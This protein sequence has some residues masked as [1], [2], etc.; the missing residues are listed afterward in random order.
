MAGTT[1]LNLSGSYTNGSISISIP[2]PAAS[3]TVA[4]A[5]ADFIAETIDVATGTANA[6]LPLPVNFTGTGLVVVKNM[7]TTNIVTLSFDT[8]GAMAGYAFASIPPGGIIAFTPLF[9]TGKSNVY[10]AAL[11]ATCKIF[12]FM[13]EL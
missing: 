3:W 5:G 2:L 10:P 9:P 1:S 11:V 13:A 4:Q 8:G 6:A 12:V 7:D